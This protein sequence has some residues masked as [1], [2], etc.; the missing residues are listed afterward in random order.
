MSTARKLRRAALHRDRARQTR[1]IEGYEIVYGRLRTYAWQTDEMNEVIERLH[2]LTRESPAEAIPELLRAIERHPGVPV[3]YNY[4]SVACGALGDEERVD[5]VV[6]ESFQRHPDY[7]FA[8]LNYA[9]L[10]LR[11]HDLEGAFKALD[12]R[13]ELWELLPRRTRFHISEFACFTYVM[14]L[15]H[16]ETGNREAARDCYERLRIAAPDD[17][18]TRELYRRLHPFRSLFHRR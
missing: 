2:H 13:L 15:F 7:L 10:C 4:L 16:L 3:F 17:R 9:E 5:E 8:R 11:R 6:R 1:T 14:G 18:Y 12:G